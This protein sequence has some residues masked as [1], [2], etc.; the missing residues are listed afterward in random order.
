MSQLGIVLLP[1]ES[2][3]GAVGLRPVSALRV[4]TRP[5]GRGRC[6]PDDHNHPTSG[7]CIGGPGR[8]VHSRLVDQRKG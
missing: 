5:T 3:L 7:V 4:S 6:Q 2:R 8:W 1:G